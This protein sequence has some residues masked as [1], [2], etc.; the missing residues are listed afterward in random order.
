MSM[1]PLL[2][3]ARLAMPGLEALIDG[4]VGAARTIIAGI[5]ERARAGEDPAQLEDELLN[6]V[7]EQPR[8]RAFIAELTRQKPVLRTV[9]GRCGADAGAGVTLGAVD[10]ADA[11]PG[12]ATTH[13][14]AFVAT[15][16]E[17]SPY[18]Q[19]LT[20]ARPYDVLVHLGLPR[21]ESLLAT[22]HAAVALLTPLR[23]G[24]WLRAV[25]DFRAGA[26]P[27]IA[28]LFLAD[29]GESFSCNCDYGS[30]HRP[31]CERSPWT[32]LPFTAPEQTTRAV[33]VL[34]QE[35]VALHV[36]ELTL[37]IGGAVGATA[38]LVWRVT[39]SFADLDDLADRSASVVLSPDSARLVVNGLGFTAAPFGLAPGRA[40][41]AALSVRSI[42]QDIHLAGG[43]GAGVNRYDEQL[44]KG[45]DAFLTDLGRLAR[46]GSQVFSTLFTPGHSDPSTPWSLPAL[47]RHEALMRGQPPLLQVVDPT[48]DDRSLVWQVIYDLPMGDD[49]KTYTPCPA[50][51]RLQEYA[52]GAVPPLCPWDE[53]HRDQRDVLCPWGFWGLSTRLEQP[54]D[55][56]GAGPSR[57]QPQTC[58]VVQGP[59]LA[60]LDA[61]HLDGLRQTLG[62]PSVRVAATGSNDDM[63]GALATDDIDVAYFYCHCGYIEG[64]P[65]AGVDRYL[66]FDGFQVTPNTVISWARSRT[67]WPRDHWR[68]RAPLVVLNGCHTGEYTSRTLASFVPAFTVWGGAGGLI[69]TEVAVHQSV[70][71]WVGQKLLTGLWSGESVGRAVFNLRWQLLARGNVMGLAYTPYC[72]GDLAI[73]SSV[74][75]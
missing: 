30:P 20:P 34:Y 67:T 37:P 29:D 75:N 1:T 71:K 59:R 32:V 70:A 40:D 46:I 15:R 54:P 61:V 35:A 48:Y 3:A 27:V 11:S 25:L 57:R 38:R 8:L 19:A 64:A 50:L 73:A 52:A 23:G 9:P 28:P 13:V 66:E 39:D 51:D 24:I 56:P 31:E 21:S 5:L 2:S 33:L 42:L 10:T 58:V 69:G 47:L 41:T 36:Q 43:D 44:G 17:T 65:G 7:S 62:H 53:D 60:P 72:R 4:D 63:A 6:L 68:T 26:P 12:V 45:H 14:S 18:P 22:D 49:P 16:G 74:A 55:R